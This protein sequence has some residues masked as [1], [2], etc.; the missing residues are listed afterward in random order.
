MIEDRGNV[1]IGRNAPDLGALA[2]GPV[3][4]LDRQ[5][6]GAQVRNLGAI[7]D[8]LKLLVDR[9]DALDGPLAEGAGVADDQPPVVILDHAGEDLRGAGAH[10]VDQDDERSVPGGPFLVVV[11]RLD[12]RG[13]LDLD[14][15]SVVDEQARQGDRLVQQAAAVAAEVDHHRVD[16]LGLEVV[17]Q[18][19]AILGGADG[20][21]VALGDGLGVAV[22]GRQVDARRS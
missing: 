20:V 3:E 19:A 10:P 18:L 5:F 8:L 1:D 11:Q 13:V 6:Q 15:G 17:E 21:G 14:D 12:A 2:V 4:L 16:L 9:D 7:A 22:E